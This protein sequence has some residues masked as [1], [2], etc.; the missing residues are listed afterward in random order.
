LTIDHAV[1]RSTKN[2]VNEVP[3]ARILDQKW[4]EVSSAGSF[5]KQRPQS[6]VNTTPDGVDEFGKAFRKTGNE[7]ADDSCARDAANEKRMTMVT[8]RNHFI[9]SPLPRRL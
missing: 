9:F 8:R 7:P 1:A 2:N 5:P 4:R 3:G 6:G